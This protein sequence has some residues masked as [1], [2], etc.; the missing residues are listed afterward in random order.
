[1]HRFHNVITGRLNRWLAFQMFDS[2]DRPEFEN[3]ELSTRVKYV[4]H[5]LSLDESRIPFQTTLFFLP[6]G[7]QNEDKKH[8]KEWDTELKQVWFSGAHSDI[9]GGMQDSRLS[10]IT[11]GWLISELETKNLLTFNKNYLVGAE[12][13]PYPISS[14]HWAPYWAT[15]EG[16]NEEV[17]MS[18]SKGVPRFFSR[19]GYGLTDIIGWQLQ[20]LPQVKRSPFYQYLA[21]IQRGEGLQLAILAESKVF[22]LL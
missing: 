16:E 9:G 15:R 18:K 5:A 19:I 17:F 10:N 12:H 3:N 7:Y 21:I 6:K 11:L 2:V 1:M 20:A 4:F 22:T 13:D 8:D 14:P